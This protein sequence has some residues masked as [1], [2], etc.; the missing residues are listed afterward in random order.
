MAKPRIILADTDVD[1]ILTIQLK[2]IE[3]Y[4]EK[5]DLEVITDEVYLKNL[6]LNP[7]RADVLI[8]SEKMFDPSLQKH[9]VG[10]TFV[11]VEEDEDGTGDL[12]VE[13]IYK[14]SS[15]KEIFNEV[16][17]KSEGLINSNENAPKETQVVLVCAAKGG[18]GKTTLS[19]AIAGALKN[20][21][22][23]VLYINAS[24]MS[25]F[26]EYMKD[27]S[28][29][30]SNDIYVK[31]SVA[32]DKIYDAVKHAI[33]TEGFSYFPALKAPLMSLGIP[34]SVYQK[35]IISAKNSKEYDYIV[36]DTD[37]VFD[38]E[39]ASL[40]NEADKVLIITKQTYSSVYATNIFASN[41]NG[42]SGEKFMFICNDF[43]H[44]NYNALI[45]SEIDIKFNVSEY[46]AH[47]S[48]AEEKG[49]ADLSK[50]VDVQKLVFGII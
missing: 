17:G 5:I 19:L 21:Y 4:F 38:E 20:N 12:W 9:N 32:N 11:L 46:V 49:C 18:V 45:S 14:Y 29:I 47:I 2:F 50:E 13:R 28:V 33:K 15:I 26:Q 27:K 42:V 6:F 24:R 40:I 3:E 36:V 44:E 7:Q 16:I 34:Y 25:Y 48:R 1:Y 30:A 10:K 43:S 8:I 22:K 39:K 41:I 35:L 31:L 37:E 23:R